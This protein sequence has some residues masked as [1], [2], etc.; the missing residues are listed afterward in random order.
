MVSGK[1]NVNVGKHIANAGRENRLVAKE[2]GTVG[3]E[4]TRHRHQLGVAKANGEQVVEDTEHGCGIGR[5]APEASA[6]GYYLMQIDVY[7]GDVHPATYELIS[8]QAEVAGM[9]MRNGKARCKK[10]GLRALD[11]LH[12]VVHPYRIKNGLQ[13]VVAVFPPTDNL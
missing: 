6:N 8:P 10:A 9:R 3:T 12:Y 2:K 5:S 1:I 11:Y 13:V 7:R 4:L